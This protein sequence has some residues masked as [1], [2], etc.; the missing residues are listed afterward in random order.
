MDW[1]DTPEEAA[2]RADVRQLIQTRLP[3]RYHDG[4][5]VEWQ[6][7]RRSDDPA[8][9][10]AAEQW[11]AALAERGWIA[12]HWPTEYGGAGLRPIEQFIFN[13]ELAAAGAPRRVGGQGVS[14]FG[15]T[16]IIHGTP[17]QK[18]E[19]LPRILH[20]E[21]LWAQGY[22]EP[23]AGSDLASL[24]TRATRDGDEYVVNGQKIWTSSAH[25]A[26]WLYTLVRTD[27]DAPK[28]R[29]ITFL[30]ID[31]STPGITIRPLVDMSFRHHFNETFFEN[32]RVPVKNRLGEEN[33]GWYIAATLL[34][35]ERSN[36]AGAVSTRRELRKLFAYVRSDDGKK[37]SRMSQSAGLHA[38]LRHELAEC[39]V[40][41]EVQLQFS[42]RIISIQAAGQ[43]PN[44]EAST[45]KLFGSE[46]HQQL[47]NTEL[48]VF[49]LYSNLWSEDDPRAPMA[50]R[51]T[52]GYVTSVSS[53]I[54]A[55]TSE[56]QRNVIAT[57]GL[58]LPRG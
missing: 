24:V 53:T 2:F 55:G 8:A 54:A 30:L 11:A 52:R 34:D 12:P 25:Y 19:H 39:Y 23:G 35:F 37:R 49:G 7:E 32:V 5:G 10:E 43:V 46:L 27:P 41:N 18:A 50:G 4:D 28:H 16:L 26:D 17:E 47:A 13:E 57:R 3:E 1:N 21:V 36:V 44:Y 31:K 56:I 51:Y 9:R 33:R 58:G 48:R 29:G 45:G 20:G 38:A 42:R 6:D 40:R 22:S 14:Q 15:P